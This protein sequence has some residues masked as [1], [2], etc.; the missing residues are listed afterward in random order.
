MESEENEEM[1]RWQIANCFLALNSFFIAPHAQRQHFHKCSV[2]QRE[3]LMMMMRKLG[4]WINF[5]LSAVCKE[6]EFNE[7]FIRKASFRLLNLNWDQNGKFL[8]KNVTVCGFQWH[9]QMFN[10]FPYL[11]IEISTCYWFSWGGFS[12]TDSTRKRIKFKVVKP[13]G[14]FWVCV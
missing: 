9:S 7:I 11:N 2:H 12:M 10:N 1:M 13:M 6:R 3:I 5:A 14:N 4:V 8:M